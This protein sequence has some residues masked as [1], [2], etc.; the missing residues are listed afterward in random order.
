[1]QYRKE[2]G[3]ITTRSARGSDFAVNLSGFVEL[4]QE[5]AEVLAD[6][7]LRAFMAGNVLRANHVVPRVYR[8][9]RRRGGEQVILWMNG[10]GFHRE[11]RLLRLARVHSSCPFYR[12]S[13]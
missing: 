11:S 1:L 4:V 3:R 6:G 7:F 12:L 2:A 8:V 10:F 9:A 13:G 5:L